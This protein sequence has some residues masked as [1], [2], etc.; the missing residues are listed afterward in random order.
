[1]HSEKLTVKDKQERK[2]RRCVKRKALNK[3]KLEKHGRFSEGWCD[4]CSGHMRWCT[5]CKTWSSDCCV[6]WGTCWCS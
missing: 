6:E 1:M 2:K 4:N 5:G 3:E